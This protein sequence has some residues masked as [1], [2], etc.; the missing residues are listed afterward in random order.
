M[1]DL[2]VGHRPL[3][4]VREDG[5]FLLIPGDDH[6][7]ALLQ[8]GLGGVLPPVP[9]SPERRLVDNVGQLR[10]GGS[11]S[12][13]GDPLK[14]CLIGHLDFLGVDLQNFLPAL[15][16]GQLHRH[17][18]VKPAR[19][20][21]SGVQG[22]RAVGR[23]QN[24]DAG[25]A[26]KA[27]HLRQELVQRLFPL[28]V[29]AHFAGVALLADGVDLVNKYDAG[30][31]FLG[32]L[33]E[34]PHLGGSHTHEHLHK[35]RAGHGKEGDVGFARHSLCQHGLAGARRAYQQNALGHGRADL[36]VLVRVVEIVHDLR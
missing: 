34:V 28:I 33:K 14:I 32:L 27:V 5:V 24:N 19:T 2:V 7:N 15:Q 10:A 8:V 6:L 9:Y 16:V 4:L 30:G 21:Q 31:F 29:A 17:P 11:R 13:P 12:H 26:L 36:F 25:V 35:L 23:G 18:A 1:A 3:L 22:F 20:G